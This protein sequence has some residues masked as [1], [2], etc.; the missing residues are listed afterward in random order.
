MTNNQVLRQIVLGAGAS[1][2]YPLG[3]DLLKLIAGDNQNS[4][5]GKITNYN[6][7]LPQSLKPIDTKNSKIECI[8]D[9]SYFIEKIKNFAENLN[10]SCA[11]SIDF[12]T[13]R[14]AD[15]KMQIVAKSLIGAILNQFKTDLE[16]SWY[17]NLLPLYFPEDIISKTANEKLQRIIEL[18]KNIRIVTFNYDLS[19]EKFLFEFLKNNVFFH[20]EAIELNTAKETIFRTI[21]HVYGSIDDPFNCDFDLIE[22]A[23]CIKFDENN[24]Y[25][26][27]NGK[28]L[29]D[30][31]SNQEKYATNINLIENERGG[32]NCK[33]IECSYLYVLGFGF[34]PINI[35]RIGMHPEKWG[36]DSN[37]GGCYVTNFGDNK[38]VERFLLNNLTKRLDQEYYIPIISKNT[39]SEALKSDFSLMEI[40][41]YPEYISRTVNEAS[42]YFFLK[43]NQF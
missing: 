3:N 2:G 5:L 1:A 39:I 28:V 14:I 18:S 37:E 11:T 15:Q 20:G 35:K 27:D 26:I 13:T 24:F 25:A 41:E 16:S 33:L 29:I 10:K 43:K 19:L 8:K 31:Y 22:D 30:A 32:G 12:Y 36:I 7:Q 42:P 4:L 34:D 38:K 17:G 40:G 21:N 9:A 6:L 23:N